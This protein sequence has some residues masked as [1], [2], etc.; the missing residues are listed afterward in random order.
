MLVAR[1]TDRAIEH[2]PDLRAVPTGDRAPLGAVVARE[3]AI[4]LVA[5]WIPPP[6]LTSTRMSPFRAETDV[7]VAT[8]LPVVHRRETKMRPPKVAPLLSLMR[9]AIASLSL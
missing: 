9:M 5:W 8:Q 1:L 2:L 4:R 6:I 7:G 3:P